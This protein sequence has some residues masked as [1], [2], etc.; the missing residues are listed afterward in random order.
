MNQDC[1]T[2]KPEIPQQQKAKPI[3]MKQLQAEEM[4][5]NIRPKLEIRS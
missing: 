2:A 5:E 1:F 3:K 4:P